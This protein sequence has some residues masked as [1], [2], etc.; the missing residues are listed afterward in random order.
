MTVSSVSPSA[1]LEARVD[2]LVERYRPSIRQAMARFLDGR[3][4]RHY[5]FMR[6]HLGWE[7]V[8]GNPIDGRTGKLLRP[9]L[10]LLSCEAVGG[11]VA[12]ALP[13]AAS[14][15]FLHN[16]TLIHDDIQD[17]SP[18]R[19]GRD[20]VWSLW[21]QALAIN[22]GDGLYALAH[23]AML[24]LAD[25]G[26]GPGTTLRAAAELDEAS[27]RLCEGQF[28][29]LTFEDRDVVSCDEY[30]AMIEGKT[31]ALM[32]ASL[33]IG[34]LVGGAN[35]ATVD[36]FREAGRRLGLAFQIRDD[37]LGVWGDPADTGKV[38][39]EDIWSRKKTYPVVYAMEHASEEDRARLK[40][41]YG[42][43]RFKQ[44]AFDEVSAI[45]E[46]SR[47][48][49][50]SDEAALRHAEAALAALDG[51][52]LRPEARGGLAILADYF[53]RRPR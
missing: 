1:S 48:R 7:D 45:L 47:A 18:K 37:V 26:V 38:T 4:L 36:A 43:P 31:A 9:V 6:Y 52:D 12:R 42:A 13:A 32:A 2:A 25:A 49:A 40:T 51:L 34:A 46:R 28:Y 24:T 10:C 29:D 14:I 15:E 27:L 53:A 30:L 22:V 17:A 33:A 20:T 3:T 19:H 39:G 16:F 21:G 35:D 11:D 5:G 23:Y 44:A 8:R 41:L 50:A